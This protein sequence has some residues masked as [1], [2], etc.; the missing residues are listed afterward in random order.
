[1]THHH[2]LKLLALTRMDRIRE[3]FCVS[4]VTQCGS[5]DSGRELYVPASPKVSGTGSE[6]VVVNVNQ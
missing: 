6:P 3:N 2:T 1:M 4:N 5:D